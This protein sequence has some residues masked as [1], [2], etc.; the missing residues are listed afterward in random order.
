MKNLFSLI[1]ILFPMLVYGQT[2]SCTPAPQAG[3]TFGLVISNCTPE[4]DYQE[5]KCYD[6]CIHE[7]FAVGSWWIEYPIKR[8]ANRHRLFHAEWITDQNQ[9]VVCSHSWKTVKLKEA[10]TKEAVSCLDQ[11]G[12]SLAITCKV[13]SG[14]NSPKRDLDR[15]IRGSAQREKAVN[16]NMT[17]KADPPCVFP[18][19]LHVW[20]CRCNNGLT[21]KKEQNQRVPQPTPTKARGPSH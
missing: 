7:Q 19:Y 21:V 4:F 9:K 11:P 8:I 20:G 1:A 16:V 12:I 3:S 2:P 6:G 14:C 10:I 18:L 5:K 17:T 15:Y 13:P